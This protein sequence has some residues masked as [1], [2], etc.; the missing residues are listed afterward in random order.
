M[1]ELTDWLNRT[2]FCYAEAIFP[3][4]R[5]EIVSFEGT[6]LSGARLYAVDFT[7]VRLNH[8]TLTGACYDNKTTWPEGFDPI[9]A[10][11]NTCR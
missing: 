5:L 7:G 4:A 10:G 6:N 2:V 8:I 9:S 11:A 1:A 3:N